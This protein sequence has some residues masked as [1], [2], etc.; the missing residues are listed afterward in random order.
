MST[1]ELYIGIS[2]HVETPDQEGCGYMGQREQIVAVARSQIGVNWNSPQGEARIYDYFFAST[3][4]KP[5]TRVECVPISWCTY[6][7]MWVLKQA[8]V[9]PLPVARLA[10]GSFSTSRFMKPAGVYN[11]HSVGEYKPRPGDLY[12]KPIPFDHIGIIDNV[13]PDGHFWSVNGNGEQPDHKEW[14]MKDV[15]KVPIP[16]GKKDPPVLYGKGCVAYNRS[17]SAT[18]KEHKYHGMKYIEIPD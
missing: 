13:E 4:K 7:V 10:F 16:P 2:R 9:Q 17:E 14:A 1:L 6:F 3:N 5:W 18:F 8:G 12:Y 15:P 11:S